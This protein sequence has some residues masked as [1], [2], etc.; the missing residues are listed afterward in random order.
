MK[1]INHQAVKMLEKSLV[2]LHREE[3]FYGDNPVMLKIVQK[4][5]KISEYLL[6][7]CN[8]KN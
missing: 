8:E 7:L 5:V 1:R 3:K 6:G 4:R 2:A